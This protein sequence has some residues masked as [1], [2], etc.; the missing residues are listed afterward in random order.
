MNSQSQKSLG[1][2]GKISNHLRLSSATI[3]TKRLTDYEGAITMR[4]L[5]GAT[6]AFMV[7]LAGATAG[8]QAVDAPHLQAQPPLAGDSVP[9]AR[10]NEA[11]P[12]ALGLVPPKSPARQQP[13]ARG[14]SWLRSSSLPEPRA[15]PPPSHPPRCHARQGCNR[16]RSGCFSHRPHVRDAQG[17]SVGSCSA[18][19]TDAQQCTA[20]HPCAARGS[21][22]WLTSSGS[23]QVLGPA[24][25]QTH[26]P[27]GGGVPGMW[28]RHPPQRHPS[29]RCTEAPR[30]W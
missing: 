29:P 18:V 24:A 26:L 22:G 2:S 23:L 13:E 6:G 30:R 1:I 17:T 3:L 12:G 8:G 5:S 21:V 10:G 11:Q 4:E 20:P 19:W 7:H 15:A 9:P 25:R 27:W 16:P 14:H 28:P